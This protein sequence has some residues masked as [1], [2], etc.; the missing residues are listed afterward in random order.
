MIPT[1]PNTQNRQHSA[2]RV[3]EIGQSIDNFI[4]T[5]FSYKHNF[6]SL[7]LTIGLTL[8]IDCLAQR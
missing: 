4:F 2:H 5:Y 8:N 7:I 1:I 6:L 3:L